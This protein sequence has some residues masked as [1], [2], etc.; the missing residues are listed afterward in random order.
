LV[1]LWL[2]GRNR[3]AFPSDCRC[4]TFALA[5]QHYRLWQQLA[6][7]NAKNHVLALKRSSLLPLSNGVAPLANAD[8][9]KQTQQY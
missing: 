1:R 9:F 5:N 4:T 7:K 8:R 3:S 2:N 6:C